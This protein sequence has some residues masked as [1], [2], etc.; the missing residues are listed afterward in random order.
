MFTVGDRRFALP[1]EEIERVLAAV[2]IIPLPD[3]PAFIRG[4]V[5][6]GGR[7]VPVFDLRVRF[8]MP[9]RRVLPSDF[10]IL[11]SREA[12][13]D[14]EEEELFIFLVDHVE[15]VFPLSIERVSFP[16]DEDGQQAGLMAGDESVV[17]VRT[18]DS[19]FSIPDVGRRA[20]DPELPAEGE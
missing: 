2:E 15:G 17:C 10:M 19:L 12:P 13:E 5:N 14:Y 7:L 1:A 9:M 4:V 18:A 11:V 8:G 3:S 20:D 16:D 6:Y